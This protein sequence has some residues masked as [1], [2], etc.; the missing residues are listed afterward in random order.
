VRHNG[1]PL[2]GHELHA[3]AESRMVPVG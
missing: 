3:G 1:A 2:Y